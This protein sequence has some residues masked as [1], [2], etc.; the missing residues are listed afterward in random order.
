MDTF[1]PMTDT[2][3]EYT[4]PGVLYYLQAEWRRFERE[5]NEW[6]I[7][8]AEFKARVALLEGERR[9]VE[10][11]KVDL[12]KRVKMLEYAL[13]QERK[14]HAVATRHS[15]A[16]NEG[17][18]TSSAADT[19]TTTNTNTNTNTNILPQASCLSS[20]S[21]K[22][23]EKTKQV[24]KDCLQEIDY[25][26]SMPTKFP[27]SHTTTDSSLRPSAAAAANAAN[28][29]ASAAITP[30]ST[31]TTSGS[32][33]G[34]LRSTSNATQGLRTGST[35]AQTT[36]ERV[37]SLMTPV[38][39]SHP[40]Q[41][42]SLLMGKT[43]PTLQDTRL[44]EDT[45]LETMSSSQENEGSPTMDL[46]DTMDTS[47]TYDTT[48]SMEGVDSAESSAGRVG[49]DPTDPLDP[50]DPIESMAKRVKDTYNVSEENIQ[51]VL[52]YANR[53]IKRTDSPEPSD[54]MFSFST[55]LEKVAT[56]QPKIWKT[57]ITMKGHLDSVR[58][59]GCH[60]TD[61]VVASGSDDGTV[62]IWQLQKS[63]EDAKVKKLAHEEAEVN[64]TYRGHTHVVTAV[65]ISAEQ[66]RVYS[67]SLDSTIRVWRLPPEDQGTYPAVD[68]S[69]NIA[70]YVGH[71]DA[72]WDF[73]LFP[74]TYQDSCLLASASADGTVKL[75]DAE[76][77]GSLLK[78]TWYY[79]GVK[80]EDGRSSSKEQ[81]AP[82]ALD[83][84]YTDLRQLVVSYTHA[85]IQVFDVE[86][87]QRVLSM[88]KSN[89]S[90]DGTHATQINC[91]VAH[92]TMPLV[93]S[94]HEDRH[95]KLYDLR[96][97]ENIFSMSAHLDAV[98]CLDIDP[99][100]MTL[101]SGGHDSSIRLW[102]LSMNKTCIQEFSAHRRKGDEGVLSVNYHRSLPWMVSS[103]ADGIVKVYY[104]GHS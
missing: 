56:G 42:P 61:M 49:E 51:K 102:D 62:K 99:S 25:L 12:A 75:W 91:L 63:I 76:T 14:R 94:G 55:T 103:G 32:R 30:T 48:E 11:V 100:G 92:P 47:D 26:I 97:G 15:E 101:V 20:E 58:T 43:T 24:L 10:N 69:V 60:P 16:K 2:P 70:T 72:I 95:I 104:Q 44:L 6:A 52:Q 68:P 86:T 67:S 21:S 31:P 40:K 23:K 17:E 34:Y 33:A 41:V 80:M 83:F 8:R 90:Y 57:R 37:S 54:D 82:T 78:S 9:G 53:S 77:S 19:I 59:V 84:S 4:L 85:M 79:D 64:M 98:A 65:A 22:K 36:T 74:V 71:T 87:G 39:L 89:S 18:E 45:G 27:L 3:A 66:N 81:V 73:K 50:T 28:A 1:Q 29:N 5:R 88:Q 38:P 93:V 13:R 46:S 96:S 7:E 35:T